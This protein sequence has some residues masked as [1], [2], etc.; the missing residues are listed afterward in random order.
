M[1]C[2]VR[3]INCEDLPSLKELITG[4]ESLAFCTLLT[5]RGGNRES[6]SP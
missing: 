2:F 1:V 3:G 5:M 6:I 4:D